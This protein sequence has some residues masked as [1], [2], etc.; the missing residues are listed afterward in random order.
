MPNPPL[1]AAAA[2]PVRDRGNLKLSLPKFSGKV[3]DWPRFWG[4]FEF[5]MKGETS[6]NDLEKIGFLEEAI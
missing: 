4:V 2:A 5:R 6:F 1:A 3:E